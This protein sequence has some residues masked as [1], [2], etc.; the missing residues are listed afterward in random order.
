MITIAGTDPPIKVIIVDVLKPH[1][2]SIVDF[3]LL[4]GK[5]KSVTH[6]DVNVYAIDEKTESVKVTVEGTNI[7]FP[8][9]KKTIE[10]FG[11]VIHSID[12]VVVG[13]GH[14]KK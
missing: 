7:D 11:A 2:P 8:K 13:N 6:M 5:E 3:G 10:D 14:K 4:V 9:V 1:K 12:R